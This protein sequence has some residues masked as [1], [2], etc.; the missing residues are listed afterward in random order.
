MSS[1][2]A[3][4]SASPEQGL[5]NLALDFLHTQRPVRVGW[6]DD[7]HAP[8]GLLRWLAGHLPGEARPQA[9]WVAPS[10]LRAL[11]DEARRLRA[12]IRALV[13]AHHRRRRVPEWALFGINRAL[14]ATPWSWRLTDGGDGMALSVSLSRA[15]PL[16]S[17]GPVALAA[18][19][20]VASVPSDRLR[21][22]ASARCGAWFV[23]T[24]KGGRRRWCSMAGCGNRE[25]AAVHRAK[26]A[27]R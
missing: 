13:E 17:L 19:R 20:L 5:G 25:K 14:A 21:P 4:S 3:L 16:C 9:E 12:D 22:C 26:R 6:V 2:R 1:L 15:E 8:D 11:L 10:E 27:R 24:S 18:A 7:L 23:D